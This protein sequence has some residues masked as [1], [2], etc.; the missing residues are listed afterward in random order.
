M[1]KAK[2][3]TTRRPAAKSA[4]AKKP[5]P[6][7]RRRATTTGAESRPSKRMTMMKSPLQTPPVER[8]YLRALV[9]RQGK[10]IGP[11]ERGGSGKK[12]KKDQAGDYFV[13]LTTFHV[14]PNRRA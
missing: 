14:L 8:E 12:A 1:G 11:G 9:G 6:Q 5:T 2:S 3:R 4:V 7:I 13:Q 10:P